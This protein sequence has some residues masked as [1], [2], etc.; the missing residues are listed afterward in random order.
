MPTQCQPPQRGDDLD[1]EQGW[2][3][4]SS[5][6]RQARNSSVPSIA[7]SASTSAALSRTINGRTGGEVI[8][9]LM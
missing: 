1:I 5:A 3:V 7:V 2:S 9:H 6:A 4:Q 8:A